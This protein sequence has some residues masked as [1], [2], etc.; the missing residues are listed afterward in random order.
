MTGMSVGGRRFGVS[1]GLGGV[2]LS[3]AARGA[4][5]RTRINRCR[6]TRGTTLS[7]ES[8]GAT[9]F[10]HPPRAVD[11][12]DWLKASAIILVSVDHFGYFFMED[13]LW[14]SAFGRLAAPIF[15]FLLG[16]AQARAIPLRW[17]WLGVVLTVL[18]SWNAEWSWVV[19]NI[20]LSLAL[21]RL[22]RPHVQILVQHDGWAGFF[23]LVCGLLA[24]LPITSKTVDYGS[25]G[26]LW[27][28]CGLCQRMYVD[29]RTVVDAHGAGE[30]A[31]SL[32]RARTENL[33]LMRLLACVVAA[34]VY[35][36]QE[37]R[38]YSFPRFQFAAFIVGI[39]VLSVSLCL[40][41]RGP[42]P[43]QPPEAIGGFLRFIG[44]HT[45]E[46]YAIQLAGF[47]LL[48]KLGLVLAP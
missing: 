4:S 31:T 20:L 35:V 9:C 2:D 38:E 42:S 30:H 48:T 11:K 10:T 19:P 33:E 32:V 14:W 16:F 22:A 45:L 17:I 27:A 12:T 34:V 37:Q 39:L 40:F 23:L 28:L 3:S 41:Q 43:I 24:V 18:Q 46:I 13:D 47:E 1:N 44:R 5:F 8:H 7:A 26:W 29:G 36:W 21:I 6:H 15:F 25:E